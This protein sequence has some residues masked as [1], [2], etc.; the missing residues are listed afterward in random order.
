MLQDSI[1]NKTSIDLAHENKFDNKLALFKFINKQDEQS[2]QWCTSEN[3]K[4]IIIIRN[5]RINF[6]QCLSRMVTLNI[7]IPK[8]IKFSRTQV[9]TVLFYLNKIQRP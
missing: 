7:S 9:D 3:D 1:N 6:T 2:E 8:K 5:E 4:L